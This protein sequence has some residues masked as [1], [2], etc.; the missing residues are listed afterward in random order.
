M[1][2]EDWMADEGLKPK[3][4]RLESLALFVLSFSV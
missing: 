1:T 2:S 4:I 3:V